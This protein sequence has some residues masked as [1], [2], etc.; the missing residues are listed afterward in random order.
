MN[1]VPPR[2]RNKMSRWWLPIAGVLTILLLVLWR[3]ARL[4]TIA[5]ASGSLA[6]MQLIRPCSGY[7][8]RDDSR[9]PPQHPF[10]AM[11]GITV[12]PAKVLRPGQTVRVTARTNCSPL[13]AV[14]YACYGLESDWQFA[15]L[16]DD[17]TSGD[18][19][20]FDGQWA[21]DI[22]WDARWQKEYFI[23]VYVDLG[24]RGGFQQN[25]GTLNTVYIM[26]GEPGQITNEAEA[27]L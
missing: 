27:Q 26:A 1:A 22:P 23:E 7:F 9:P 19:Q 11:T 2:P 6:G 21:V 4:A 16:H 12:T 15:G 18:G 8:V 3:V 25:D 10:A 13:F 17:G 20:P 24:V 5:A 14:P